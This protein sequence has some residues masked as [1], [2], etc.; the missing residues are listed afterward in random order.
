MSNLL[1]KTPNLA[2][3]GTRAKLVTATSAN[4][5]ANTE[6]VI[7]VPA[8]K[9]YKVISASITCVQGATQ[10]PLPALTVKNAAGVIVFQ[11]NGSTTVQTAGVTSQYSWSHGA[12][13]TAGAALTVN[14]AP[15]PADLLLGP[16]FTL[17]T[18]TAGKGANTDLGALSALV[19]E[20]S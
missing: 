10:T 4:P 8:N 14:T 13:L 17:E 5:A 11:Q 9:Y 1:I 3:C 7:T 15:I 19:V 16:A 12:N 6:A 20:L 18:A 2:D